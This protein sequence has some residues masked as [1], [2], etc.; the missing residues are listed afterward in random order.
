MFNLGMKRHDGN[1]WGRKRHFSCHKREA[2]TQVKNT[3]ETLDLRL[4]VKDGI[5]SDTTI[6]I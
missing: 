1:S 3:K 6:K 2:K 5:S 4:I